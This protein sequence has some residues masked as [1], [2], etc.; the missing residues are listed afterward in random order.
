MGKGSIMKRKGPIL[1]FAFIIAISALTATTPANAASTNAVP[2]NNGEGAASGCFISM[3][4][5]DSEVFMPDGTHTLKNA[6]FVSNN[7][8]YVP[9]R[10]T[11]E[12]CGGI[13][14]YNGA[15]K[16]VLIALPAL[17]G[18][19]PDSKF[20][21]IW[22]GSS[23]VLNNASDESPLRPYLYES[24]KASDYIPIARNGSVFVPATYFERFGFGGVFYDAQSS[25]IL[26]SNFENGDHL[27]G[28]KVDSD[29]SALDKVT[30]DRFKLID[31]E[32]IDS[33]ALI[34]ETFSD[35]DVELVIRTGEQRYMKHEGVK[36]EVHMVTLI[37]DK[38]CTPR[39]LRVGD[40][41]EKVLRLYG[42]NGNRFTDGYFSNGRIKIQIQD[43]KVVRFSIFSMD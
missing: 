14:R 19:S 25:V 15:D 29:F 3:K 35:G 40:G 9:L 4:A 17:P 5:G 33:G 39:G 24:G 36:E 11:V 8:A 26:I 13:V 2:S 38:Y 37:S 18:I 27:A 20:S 21:Q 43:G 32:E 28:F 7:I 34:E 31:R 10:E 12:L 23:R 41:E 22:I 42:L 30:R 1:F 16:S 6:P